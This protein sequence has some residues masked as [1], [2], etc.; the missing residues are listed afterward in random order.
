MDPVQVDGNVTKAFDGDLTTYSSVPRDKWFRVLLSKRVTILFVRFKC[1]LHNIFRISIASVNKC[2][3]F[4][5]G[6]DFKKLH[7]CVNGPM[8][9]KQILV[10]LLGNSDEIILNEVELYG[11]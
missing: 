2:G 9:T 7:H 1:G 8:T 4:K 10:M 3:D 5:C 11:F 6:T